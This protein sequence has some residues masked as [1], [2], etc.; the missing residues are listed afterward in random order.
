MIVFFRQHVKRK[1][2]QG[3]IPATPGPFRRNKITINSPPHVL[4]RHVGW[5]FSSGSS[6][7]A[8]GVRLETPGIGLR[9]GRG[10]DTGMGTSDPIRQAFPRRKPVIPIQSIMLTRPSPSVEA[11]RTSRS[12]YVGEASVPLHL[13]HAPTISPK[14]T[15]A[16]SAFPHSF[17]SPSTEFP[18]LSVILSAGFNPGHVRPVGD[19]N[20]PSHAEA[21][22]RVMAVRP[23]SSGSAEKRVCEYKP[24]RSTRARPRRTER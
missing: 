8:K 6:R 3:S 22:A 14:T 11:R 20:L 10:T 12:S 9:D 5:V 23:E 17:K 16:A 1:V 24:P 21:S 15:R 2:L 18:S 4:F 7:R 19:S 13:G